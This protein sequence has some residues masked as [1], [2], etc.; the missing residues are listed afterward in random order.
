MDA[1]VVDIPFQDTNPEA[2]IVSHMPKVDQ[3]MYRSGNKVYSVDLSA[4]E[5][6]EGT[7]DISL[8]SLRSH[9]NE[10]SGYRA[11]Y[12]ESSYYA[13]LANLNND[14]ASEHGVGKILQYNAGSVKDVDPLNP[15][16]PARYSKAESLDFMRVYA[17]NLIDNANMTNSRY[18][19]ESKS[20][21]GIDKEELARSVELG[22]AILKYENRLRDDVYTAEDVQSVFNT[23]AEREMDR[24]R[25]KDRASHGITIP[26]F[27]HGSADLA[28]SHSDSL[29]VKA[30]HDFSRCLKDFDQKVEVNRQMSAVFRKFSRHKELDYHTDTGLKLGDKSRVAIPHFS[31][32]KPYVLNE[33]NE[34]SVNNQQMYTIFK[35]FQAHKDV[36][37]RAAKSSNLVSFDIKPHVIESKED[38]PVEVVFDKKQSNSRD[39]GRI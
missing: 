2:H 28:A 37:F 22:K 26:S 10:L 5:R 36:V 29:T 11:Q 3:V 8:E 23:I 15:Y 21:L 35:N 9:S 32:P 33:S 19:D 6:G 1:N 4:I 14:K 25:E 24:L 34:S 7:I 30:M 20:E 12:G 39:K 31:D 18:S 27:G 13:M 17:A 38:M 16:I